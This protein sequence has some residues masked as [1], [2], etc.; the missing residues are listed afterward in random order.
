M[1]AAADVC[2]IL[3]GTY[4]YVRGGVAEWAHLLIERLPHLTFHLWCVVPNAA[5]CKLAYEPPKNVTGVTNVHLFEDPLKGSRE[6]VPDAVFQIA[7][8]FHEKGQGVAGRMRV[9]F[10]RLAPVLPNFRGALPAEELL[11]GDRAYDLL[12]ELYTKNARELPFI[13]YFYTYLFSHFPLFKLMAAGVP[14]ARLYH[15]I[16]TG[17]AGFLGARARQESGRPLLLTEHGIYTNERTVEIILA[18]WVYSRPKERISIGTSGQSLKKVWMDLFDFL[19]RVTYQATDRITTLFGGNRDLQIRL[20]ADAGKIEVIS[21]GV[22]LDRFQ[23]GARALDPRQPLVGL[24]GRVVA[25]K[26]VRTFVRACRTVADRIPEA[27]FAVIGPTDQEPAYY[28]KCLDQR[29]LLRLED[30]LTFTGPANV[31][32][33]YA[34]LDVLALT[35]VSEGLPLTVLEGSA[36]GVPLVCTRVGACE[37]L[38]NGRT[39]EDRALGPS[40]LVTD[41]GDHRA[42]GR[43]IAAILADRGQ[44][45]RLG[46]AGRQRVQR[47]YDLRVIVAEYDRLYRDWLARSVN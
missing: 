29:R 23:V 43:A 45:R 37:E 36:C 27:R 44:A 10:E 1:S 25:I 18:E 31:T 5:F 41:V 15:T 38:L 9:L 42:I 7:R 22:D 28:Q 21:N 4:P 2:L 39:P 30:R 32:E 35:S 34:K 16:A 13:D 8:E 33:W 46:D 14:P 26:D 47:F 3:E 20:G 24:V 19:G 12:V 17:Y 40:G 11:F 6:P